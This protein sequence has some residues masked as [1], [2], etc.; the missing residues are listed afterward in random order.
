MPRRGDGDGG[1]RRPGG[2]DPSRVFAALDEARFGHANTLNL[3]VSLPTVAEALAR[4]EP[5]LRERQMAK[6]GEVLVITGRG[7]AS[8]GG[9]SPVREAIARLLGKLTR[10]GVVRRHDEHTAGSFVVTL[11]KVSALYE[12]AARR[13]H[14]GEQP[15]PPDPAALQALAPATRDALRALAVRSLQQ[16]GAASLADRFVATEMERQFAHLSAAVGEA[17]GGA[18]DRDARLQRLAEAALRELD[19][20]E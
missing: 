5:W 17:G 3:R 7:N 14:P 2:S 10:A 13:R 9:V 15:P 6:A 12:A 20:E 4:A 16:L 11:A 19:E 18:D 1:G 8:E